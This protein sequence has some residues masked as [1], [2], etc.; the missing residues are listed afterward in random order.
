METLFDLGV[1]ERKWGKMKVLGF[2]DKVAGVVFSGDNPPCCGVPLGG[3]GTGC[4]DFDPRGYFG[5]NTIFNGHAQLFNTKS[6]TPRKLPRVQPAFCISADDSVYVLAVDKLLNGGKMPW[7]TAP[8]RARADANEPHQDWVELAAIQGIKPV[9]KILYYGHYPVADAEYILDAPISVGI[10]GWSPFVPGDAAVS[11][12]PCAVFEVHI[13]NTSKRKVKSSLVMNFPGPDTQEARGIYFKKRRV[14][15]AA[16]GVFVSSAGGVNYFV[17]VYGDER[18]RTGTGLHSSEDYS[19]GYGSNRF[20]KKD[21]WA[22]VADS[23]PQDT[24]FVEIDGERVYK[25]P[26]VS[27][28]VDF[29]LEPGQEKKVEFILA[30]YAPR[31]DSAGGGDDTTAF[32]GELQSTWQGIKEHGTQLYLYHNYAVRYGNALDVMRRMGSERETIKKRIF[33]WQEVLL[34]RRELPVWLRDSLCNILCLLAEDGYWVQPRYP[35][36]DWAYPGGAFFYF[37]SPRDCPHSSCIPND[38][39]S[40]LHIAYLFPDLCLQLLRAFKGYQKP[41][42]EIPFALGRV[43]ELPNLAAPEYGWQVS[44][45]SSCYIFMVD[46]LWKIAGNDAVI[47]EFYESIKKCN[48]F[49][50]SLAG[51]ENGILRMPDRG[52]SEWFEHSKFYGLTSHV[53]GL[54]LSQLLIVERMARHMGDTDYADNCRAVFTE[55]RRVFEKKLWNGTHYLTYLDEENVRQNDNIMAYQ[56][57]GFCTNKQ[58]GIQDTILDPERIAIALD[59]IWDTNVAR[60]NGYGA[61]NYVHHDGTLLDDEEDAYGKHSIFTQNTIILAITYLYTGQYERGMELARSTWENLVLKQGLGWDMTHIVHAGDG[62]K[63]FGADY[64]QQS[65]IWML[66]AALMGT[67]IAGPAGDGGLVADMLA[68]AGKAGPA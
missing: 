16:K 2:R 22:G 44:L 48:D 67:D 58:A 64:N 5:W 33:A 62:H 19:V 52:G 63:M 1:P 13:R 38:W 54:H 57:D 25:D 17:G 42:G 24:M 47:N 55:N 18:Y 37:E 11:N 51:G 8:L 7:C 43:N 30:W 10:R 34:T 35:I 50:L 32:A 60:G 23:L 66:P 3:I 53:G 26:S 49:V 15:E 41:D 61:L 36:G 29:T 4:I 12:I 46:R 27:L 45:N 56:L 20:A 31:I 39:I 28:A 14:E 59:T 40:T 9:K 6:R 21:S 65:V 68:A